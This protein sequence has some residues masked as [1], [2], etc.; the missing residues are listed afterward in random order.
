M[1]FI[2]TKK[3]VENILT[4]DRSQ[5][6]YDAKQIIIL[7]PNSNEFNMMTSLTDY[8]SLHCVDVNG[9]C[10][11]KLYHITGYVCSHVLVH[12]HRIALINIL[13]MIS[14]I[15]I[16]M[17]SGR[18]RNRTP[19]LTVDPGTVQVLKVPKIKNYI[20]ISIWLEEYGFGCIK[21]YL[22]QGDKY[23]AIFKN[24]SNLELRC[25]C[26]DPQCGNGSIH[27]MLSNI[28]VEKGIK[29]AFDKL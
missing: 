17:K 27:K 21:K 29:D 16:E 15:D 3:N 28:E 4:A 11:C 2:N 23:L 25:Q 20:M 26:S 1:L 5:K 13:E 14:S 18:K 19:A 9:K 7:V 6:Y 10:D 12:Y 24:V 22:P 8:T